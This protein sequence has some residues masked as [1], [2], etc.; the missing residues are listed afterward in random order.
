MWLLTT[1]QTVDQL[2]VPV[3]SRHL[4]LFESPAHQSICAALGRLPLM[5]GNLQF[6][7]S[8][9]IVPR[10][11]VS[12]GD[13][14]ECLL[15]RGCC[16]FA[17]RCAGETSDKQFGAGAQPTLSGRSDV[18]SVPTRT[19]RRA[20]GTPPR[21]PAKPVGFAGTARPSQRKAWR[22]PA[23]VRPASWRDGI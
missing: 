4:N 23:G 19:P 22:G 1:L 12:D 9:P 8:M 15:T 18:R 14:P 5:R 21:P 13:A 20:L 3:R 11:V 17:H 16:R 10:R 7:H 6:L 2:A